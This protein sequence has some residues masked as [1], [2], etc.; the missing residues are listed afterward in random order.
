VVVLSDRS[1]DFHGLSREYVHPGR[2]VVQVPDRTWPVERPEV[3]TWDAPSGVWFNRH[4]RPVDSDVSD[5]DAGVFL[6][7]PG[8]GL[9]AT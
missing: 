8:C 9:D 6:L 5:L 2:R 4:G 1:V 3:C 7:C